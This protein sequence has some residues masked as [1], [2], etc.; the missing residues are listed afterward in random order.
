MMKVK[1]FTF[2][3]IQ[4]RKHRQIG[5][6]KLLAQ[7]CH[8]EVNMAHVLVPSLACRLVMATAMAAYGVQ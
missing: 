5:G 2:N 1:C 4:F 6:K 8:L 3:C 7:C